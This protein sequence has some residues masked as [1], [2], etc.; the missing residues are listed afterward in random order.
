MVV[1][2]SLSDFSLGASY[3]KKAIQLLADNSAC[4][5]PLASGE[6]QPCSVGAKTCDIWVIYLFPLRPRPFV[7]DFGLRLLKFGD[8]KA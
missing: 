3:A 1:G 2:G 6:A 8:G 7:P 5:L 4:L